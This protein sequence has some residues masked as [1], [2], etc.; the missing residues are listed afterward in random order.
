LRSIDRRFSTE[1]LKPRH[2][3]GLLFWGDPA[4][5]GLFPNSVAR[6]ICRQTCTQ[7]LYFKL[8]RLADS[9]VGGDAGGDGAGSIYALPPCAANWLSLNAKLIYYQKLSRSKLTARRVQEEER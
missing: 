8:T 1:K 5:A 2:C 9:R 7:G 4:A 6:L 3:P